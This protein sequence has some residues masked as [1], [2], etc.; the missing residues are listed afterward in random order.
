MKSIFPG[1]PDGMDR[2]I[3]QKYPILSGILLKAFTCLYNFAGRIHTHRPRGGWSEP[4]AC[5]LGI[6][7]SAVCRID[8]YSSDANTKVYRD[9]SAIL[10]IFFLP[11]VVLS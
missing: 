8:G 1:R 9:R 2:V 4:A 6:L 11:Q 3:L 7:E 10:K 5:I